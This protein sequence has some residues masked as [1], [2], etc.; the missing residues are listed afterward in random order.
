MTIQNSQFILG[1]NKDGVIDSLEMRSDPTAMNW[2]ITETYLKEVGFFGFDKLFGNFDLKVENKEY[3]SF[4]AQPTIVQAEDSYAIRYDFVDF[5]LSQKF[6]MADDGALDW[7]IHFSNKK[8]IAMKIQEFGIWAS[9]SYI[10]YRDKNVKRNIYHSAAV[11]PSVSP[12]LTKLAVMRRTLDENSIGLYQTE[13]STVSLGTYCEFSNKFF[14]APA[15]SLDGVIY[16]KL[17]L[18]QGEAASAKD[19]IYQTK[20]LNVASGAS[21]TWKYRMCAVEDMQ[22]FYAK[23]MEVG[24]AA[25]DYPSVVQVGETFEIH[26]QGQG[27]ESATAGW[28]EAGVLMHQPIAVSEKSKLLCKFDVP[29]EHKLTIKL[30]NGKTDQLVLNVMVDLKQVIQ[31]RVAYLCQT[32]YEETVGENQYAFNPVSNQGESLGKLSLILKKNLLDQADKEEIRKVE[33]SINFYVIQKWFADKQFREPKKVYG[34][35]Y[36]VMDFEYLGHVLFLLSQFPYEY[37]SVQNSETYLLWATQVVEL[38]INPELHGDLRGKEEAEMLGVFFLYIDDLIAALKQRGKPEHKKLA[39]LWENNLFKILEEKRELKAAM[40]EHYFDNAGFGPAAA[41]LANAGYTEECKVYSDLLLA[42]IGFSNDFRSQNPDRWWE[43]LSYMI[44]SLWGGISAAAALDVFHA[45]KDPKYLLASYRAFM[46]VLYCY[47]S[48]ATTTDKLEKGEAASTYSTA[49]P[50][51]NR[52][53]LTLNRFGQ[54][55]F[56]GDGGIFSKIFAEGAEQTSDWDM[57][58]ELVAYLDRFGQ[59]A[60]CFFDEQGQ[61]IGVNCEV[62]EGDGDYAIL[63]K[64]PY[65]RRIYLLE[66]DAL[67]E[68]EGTGIRASVPKQKA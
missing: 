32:S 2:V 11:F 39:L 18:A 4:Q 55:V 31:E 6:I 34:D 58:E 62:K 66:D 16:H 27:I 1:V 59:D 64:A 63:N 14:E 68:L 20:Q 25:Y 45:I 57:G 52:P 56:A 37:L 22:D 43:S 60:Y 5:E 9:F 24:H 36:R 8:N 29:G 3:S 26:A 67:L 13:G 41:S 15:P 47:D 35:F 10:M 61:L 38:R 7:E 46:G 42:N 23:G 50:H 28:M 53:D 17:I 19:W 44:H 65:P 48:N 49:N 30:A 33:N 21:E 12:D 40:T 51:Y 54:D